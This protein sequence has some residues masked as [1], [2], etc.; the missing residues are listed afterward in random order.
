MA[1]RGGGAVRGG[2]VARGG[3]VVA[4]GGVA[5]KG[6]GVVARGGGAATGGAVAVKG[7][8]GANVSSSNPV[9][10]KRIVTSIEKGIEILESKRKRKNEIGSH[11]IC[12]KLLS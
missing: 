4:R 3:G 2:V 8:G 5:A 1:A 6:G 12:L 11:K 9:K 7:T 10:G